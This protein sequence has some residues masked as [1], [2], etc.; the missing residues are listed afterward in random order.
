MLNGFALLHGHFNGQ[1]A[2]SLMP[3]ILNTLNNWFDTLPDYA[4]T[5]PDARLMFAIFT[6]GRKPPRHK[7]PHIF[8]EYDP[9]VSNLPGLSN[10][11]ERTVE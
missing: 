8:Y 1:L 9:M 10:L 2:L 5:S 11:G 6:N 7:Q 3:R 4:R